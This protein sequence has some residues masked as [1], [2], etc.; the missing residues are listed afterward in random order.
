MPTIDRIRDS[1][2]RAE[3]DAHRGSPAFTTMIG[4]IAGKQAERDR[5]AALPRDARRRAMVR[6][7]L[8]NDPAD[9]EDL[10]HIHSVLAMCGLP[11]TRQ[12]LEV[13]EYE[14]RQGRM[15][16]VVEA[17][18]LRNPETGD[19]VAQP[20][21]FGPKSRLL[22]MHLCSEAIRQKSATIE[23]ADSLT[24]FIRDMGFPVTGG[25]KGTLN[26]FKEQI[27]A[28]AACKLSVGMWDGSRAVEY[29]GMPF[30]RIDVWLP[31]HPDQMML[32]PST[33][34]FSMDFY[35]TLARHA[36]PIRAEAVR[37][38]AGSARKLD[39]YFWFNYRLHR[40]KQ[41]TTLSWDALAGQFGG[42][43]DRQRAFRAHFA[44]DLRDILDVFP[45][46]PVKLTEAGLEV[47]PTGPEVLSLPGRPKR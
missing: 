29:Q 14:R 16:L 6:R 9:K 31:T 10:R 36:L 15:S 37:A 12:P 46:L 26:A 38:F 20:L 23:I 24:G 13:R 8:E 21:P 25:K 2:L 7:A 32:W 42:S 39:M 33:L 35:T 19:R 3:L 41:P 5:L 43:F 27:N 34:T 22:L 40:L 44:D 30:S 47:S 11:Y 17:G 1:D 4:I 18:K 45:K 28:L